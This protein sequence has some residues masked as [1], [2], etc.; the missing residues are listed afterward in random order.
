MKI[1]VLF[2]LYRRPGDGE[3]FSP[4]TLERVEGKPTEADVLRSLARL[5]H[6]VE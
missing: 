6:D 5:G 2:D 1:L 4:R 3:R